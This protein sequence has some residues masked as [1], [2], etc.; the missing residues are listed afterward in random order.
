MALIRLVDWRTETI[1]RSAPADRDAV[2]GRALRIEEEVVCVGDR[3][4]AIPAELVPDSLRQRLGRDHQRVE[5]QVGARLL[6][7]LHGEGLGCTHD[8]VSADGAV[9]CHYAS[10][11]DK[12]RSSLLVD[13]AALALH[14][15]GDAAHEAG[16][17]DTRAVRCERREPCIGNRDTLGDL[18]WAQRANILFAPTPLAVIVDVGAYTLFLGRGSRDAQNAALDEA[19]IDLLLRDTLANPI[20]GLPRRALGLAHGL[21]TTVLGPLLGDTRNASRN[22]ATIATRCAKAR[23]LALDHA[24]TQRR[25]GIEQGIR[26]PETGHARAHDRDVTI[27]VALQRGARP[28]RARERVEPEAPVA[29]VALV[30]HGVGTF[31]TLAAAAATAA[32]SWSHSFVLD[33]PPSVP[34]GT[35]P[36]RPL[37][38]STTR[39]PQYGVYMS[40]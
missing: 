10:G 18:G 8:V 17:I 39:R 31:G 11:F 14:S 25:I 35:P 3:L 28:N 16:R 1:R 6:L 20:D 24:H 34:S 29:D 2:V 40:E 30:A 4:A 5:R 37:S 19:T 7:E 26:S 36:S 33:S 27:R 22:P 23:N 32:R 12:A 38:V 21:G 15:I 13:H 9:L